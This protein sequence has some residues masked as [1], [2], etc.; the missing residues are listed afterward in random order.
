MK[1]AFF[2]CSN[3]TVSATDVPNL[4]KVTNMYRMF[5]QASSANPDVSNWNIGSVSNMSG[6]FADATSVEALAS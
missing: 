1:R 5:Q 2:R 3:L 4:S 6:I